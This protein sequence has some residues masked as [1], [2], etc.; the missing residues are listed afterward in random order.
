MKKIINYLK[1]K[2]NVFDKNYLLILVVSLILM[3][4]L[5]SNEYFYGHDTKYHISNILAMDQ[6]TDISN[7]N[8]V[9][10][11]VTPTIAGDFGWGAGLFYPS[12]PHDTALYIYKIC[13]IFHMDIFAS[14][15][16]CHF[17]T[18]ILSGIFMYILAKKLFKNK[19]GALLSSI[20]YMT[21]PYHI[22]DIFIRDA[23]AE[24]FIFIFMPVIFL[25]L[26]YLFKKN[27]KRFLL[28]FVLGY[29][30]A[31]NSHLVMTVYLTFFVI[32][33]LLL[34]IKNIWNKKDILYLF[35]AAIVI[36]G[37]SSPFWIPMLES[38][39]TNSCAIFYDDFAYDRSSIMSRTL[40]LNDYFY[41][42]K[43]NEYIFFT[44]SFTAL[45]S[46]LLVVLY[47]KKFVKEDKKMIFSFL[48]VTFIIFIIASPVFPWDKMPSLLLN[49][50]FPWRIEIFLAFFISLIGG[51]SLKFFKGE[52]IQ[53]LFL[54]FFST[55]SVILGIYLVHIQNYQPIDMNNINISTHGMAT[56]M[57]LP[58]NTVNNYEYFKERDNNV[59]IT[60]GDGKIN[61]I[62]N[63]TPYLSFNIETKKATLELPR[64]YYLG[65]NIHYINEKNKIQY[66]EN[67]NGFI[68]I[69]VKQSGTIEVS[70]EGTTGYK[71]SRW[72]SLMTLIIFIIFVVRKK[73]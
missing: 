42:P 26:F 41:F 12:L 15:K 11:K 24:S 45:I 21:F 40:S 65:Y 68:E 35:I 44:I 5:F 58:M 48:V 56:N 71:I 29:L 30:G 19:K 67:D 46:L 43:H 14:L 17:I 2:W 69:R 63:E 55:I 54:I 70:Y 53:K 57:Y 3:A 8:L 6:N 7:G 23:F 72:V 13:K 33:Y 20:F 52:E 66:T 62:K 51:L 22:L 49:I 28:F 59:K 1:R 34:N 38:R 50:Q 10:D 36:L 61:I 4:P 27:Y 31:I 60:N 37:L 18:M 73:K 32:I 47:F 25:G 16:I 9:P 64:L 39:F